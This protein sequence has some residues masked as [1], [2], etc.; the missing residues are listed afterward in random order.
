MYSDDDILIYKNAFNFWLS[1]VSDVNLNGFDLGFIRVEYEQKSNER[2]SLIDTLAGGQVKPTIGTPPAGGQVNLTIGTHIE[3]F[4][5]RY[6][7]SNIFNNTITN[8]N[9]SK[10]ICN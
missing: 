3:G 4:S 8:K 6:C 9:K 5:D 2:N 1:N 7:S 10:N